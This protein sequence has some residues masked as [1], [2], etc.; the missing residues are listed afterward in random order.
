M[1]DAFTLTAEPA[2]RMLGIIAFLRRK[3]TFAKDGD[4]ETGDAKFKGTF[5]F[6]V[7]SAKASNLYHSAGA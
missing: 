7:E 4:F 2:N 5:R 1:T 6:S 3:L